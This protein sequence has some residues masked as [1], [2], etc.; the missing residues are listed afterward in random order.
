MSHCLTGMLYYYCQHRMGKQGSLCDAKVEGYVVIK[1]K[2]VLKPHFCIQSRWSKQSPFWYCNIVRWIVNHTQSLQWKKCN[3]NMTTVQSK[4]YSGAFACRCIG[5]SLH[6]C[7]F[8]LHAQCWGIFLKQSLCLAP[9][10]TVCQYVW[11]AY[12]VTTRNH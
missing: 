1:E 9:L 2:L 4:H 8:R 6:N 5:Y 7:T 12:F 3:Q 11:R 10:C